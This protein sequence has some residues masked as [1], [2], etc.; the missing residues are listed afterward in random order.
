LIWFTCI[1]NAGKARSRWKLARGISERNLKKKNCWN[2]HSW[3]SL[4]STTEVQWSIFGA[5]W[6][7]RW[8]VKVGWTSKNFDWNFGAKLNWIFF[9]VCGLA[10]AQLRCIVCSNC[11]NV[12]ANPVIQTCTHPPPQPP[13]GPTTTTP[14]PTTS[15]TPQRNLEQLLICQESSVIF[16]SSYSFTDSKSS[17]TRSGRSNT[18]SHTHH[19]TFR[20]RLDTTNSTTSRSK[21]SKLES[22]E[23]NWIF[24]GNCSARPDT[25]SNSVSSRHHNYNSWSQCANIHTSFHQSP[26]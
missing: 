26:S 1:V 13:A 6:W 10:E 16:H 23:T 5:F 22:D 7:L 14:G 15:P 21:K 25:C 17:S 2:V 9:S 24:T 8:L 4:L 19:S 20:T 18:S 12:P 3:F 11:E